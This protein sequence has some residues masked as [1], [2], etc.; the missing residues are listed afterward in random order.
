VTDVGGHERFLAIDLDAGEVTLDHGRATHPLDSPEAFA[1]ISRAWLR[2]GWDTKYVYSFTWMGRPIIQLPDD[3]VRL[4]EVIHS[5]RPDVIVETGIAHGGSLVFS[6]SLCK[7][8]DRGRVI[9]VDI[10]IRPYNRAAIEAHPLKYLITLIEGDSTR[11]DIVERV[12]SQI[13]PG[14]TVL[15]LLDSRHTRDHVL[16]ELEA[17]GQL[18]TPSSY[19]VAMDGIMEQ[20]LGAPR[21]QPDW[22]WNNPRQAVREFLEATEQFVLEEPAFPFNEGVVADRV[23][24]WPDAFLRRVE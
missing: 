20:L 16:A 13:A 2:C 18:V 24:Y 6:A 3:M 22:G 4:Q 9:G 11:A 23:T 12:R 15:V 8:L 17:Y 19:I 1:A 7:V 10:E 5:V 21:T 14:E